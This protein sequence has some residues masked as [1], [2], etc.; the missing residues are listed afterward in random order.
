MTSKEM[1]DIEIGLTK[2]TC[3]FKEPVVVKNTN[4]QD[5]L[6]GK[7]C[8]QRKVLLSVRRKGLGGG[9]EGL[10]FRF[11]HISRDISELGSEHEAKLAARKVGLVYW[12]TLENQQL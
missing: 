5:R 1:R 6:T 4:H 7:C 2:A 12:A 10:C 8:I 9:P 11:E 3:S